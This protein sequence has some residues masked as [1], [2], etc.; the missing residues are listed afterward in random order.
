MI[1]NYLII[2]LRSFARNRNYSLINILGL[3]IGITCAIIIYLMIDYELQ[4]DQFH[5]KADR[6]FRVVRDSESS[7][8]VEHSGITPYPFAE[9][10][11]NDFQDVPFNTQFHDNEETLISVE[12][13]KTMLDRVIFADSLFF[14]VFDFKVLSGNPQKDLSQPNKVFL[15]ESLANKIFR[16]GQYKSI[17]VNNV[18]TVEVAGILA[19]PPPTSHIQFD[20]IVSM[21]SLSEE[22][23]G[24]A[25]DQWGMNSAGYSYI[26]L[27][28]NLKVAGIEERFTDFVKKYYT[29]EE[30]RQQYKLQPLSDI[31]FNADY[32][33][34]AVSKSHLTALGF[35]AIFIVG[36]ACM[37]F[38]NLATALAIKKS[39]EIG[40]R[41]TLGAVRQQLTFY[42]LGQTFLLTALAVVM[43]LGIVEW[44]MP[45]LNSF[46]EKQ[47]SADLLG[48]SSLIVFLLIVVIVV[49][50]CSGLY[51][52][53]ILSGFSPVAVLKSN[54]STMNYSGASLRKVLVVFQFLIAQALII[55]TL[56]I[57]DQMD[58]FKSKPL[59]FNKEAIINVDMP[60]RKQQVLQAFRTRLESN[61]AIKNVSLSIG[62]PISDNG[63]GTNYRLTESDKS[64][65]YDVN[66]KTADEN[67]FETYGLKIIAGRAMTEAE[68]KLADEPYSWEER[69]YVLV[70]NE[71]AARQ[72]GFENPED[73]LGKYLTV[74]INDI[75]APVVGVVEDFH[76]SSMHKSI[77]PVIIVNF[78]YFYVDAGIQIQT[79]NM[80]ETLAFIEKTWNELHPDYYFEYSF[81]DDELG[82]LY[83]QEERTLTLFKIFSMIAI[84][85]G[86]LGLYGLISFMA[87]QKMK[88]VGIRKV[89]GASVSSIVILFSR[90]FVKLICVAFVIAAPLAWYIM[91]KWLEEFAYRIDINWSVFVI[92]IA[93]TLAIAF[94]TVGFRALKAALTDPARTLR[95]E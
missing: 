88:E 81:L 28:Q 77:E 61:P 74:G 94:L 45:W 17:K 58:F 44:L 55:G 10:F 64:I 80:A 14:S 21:P 39:R 75:N 27:P 8:G 36:I 7:S 86:C 76:T 87:T 19:D 43:S 42:F 62:A 37:N 69:K 60:D 57:V 89:L 26:V 78:P 5:S 95:T 72:I 35:L 13:K 52:A 56:V 67:Y 16:E 73:I 59:G 34:R 50:I 47:L 20:M 11:R 23:L 91:N 4:F 30:K 18:I 32:N 24:L 90:E 29:N 70:V 12:G 63:L 31:H 83:R 53:I 93:S 46:L 3:S 25:I 40:I 6:I 41:K 82:K 33:T 71:S 1:K 38:I 79:G 22:F 85:I 49:T 15:T 84:F 9:A 48:E 2:T 65:F 54:L 68:A 66:V 51:P 92:S